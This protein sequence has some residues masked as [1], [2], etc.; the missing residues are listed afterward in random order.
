MVDYRATR[1]KSHYQSN[2][3]IYEVLCIGLDENQNEKP[4][5]K[6]KWCKF[7]F[8]KIPVVTSEVMGWVEENSYKKN[9]HLIDTSDNTIRLKTI[10]ELCEE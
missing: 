1:S 6:G 7:I 2:S 3:H 10:S 9:L 5:H 8:T 4:Y